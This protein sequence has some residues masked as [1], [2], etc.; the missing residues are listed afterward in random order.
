MGD[1][2]R[3]ASS[4]LRAIP[5]AWPRF[6][7]AWI[8][9]NCC[10]VGRPL[11]V[12]TSINAI[13]PCPMKSKSLVP[14]GKPDCI[15]RPSAV[16]NNPTFIR[17]TIPCLDSAIRILFCMSVSVVFWVSGL[18]SGLTIPASFIGCT[19]L[20]LLDAMPSPVC[21]CVSLRKRAILRMFGNRQAWCNRPQTPQ[22]SV[23]VLP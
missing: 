4:T 14:G 3:S 2:S 22:L 9:F 1:I 11:C 10:G 5:A 19:P 15:G 12:L 21:S 13:F 18:V 20:S 7:I 17:N 6:L 23:T 16:K 8:K